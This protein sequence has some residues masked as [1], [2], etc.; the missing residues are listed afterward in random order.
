M[1]QSQF[2]IKKITQSLPLLARDKIEELIQTGPFSPGEKLP[3]ETGL[4]EMLGVS[5]LTIREALRLLEEDGVIVRYQ[6]KGTFVRNSDLIIRNPLE[7]N[8]S[9]TE[10]IQ[11]QGFKA[12]TAWSQLKRAHADRILA[13]TLGVEVESTVVMLER[14]RTASGKPAVYTLD[15]LPEKFIPDMDALRNLQ[16]S[17][18]AFLEENCNQKI[19]YS[20]SKLFPILSEP[21]IVNKLKIEK[22]LPLLLLEEV[23]YTRED[24]PVMCGREYWAPGVFEFSLI[25]RRKR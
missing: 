18:S 13:N 24:K 25:R 23:D 14:V 8:I 7:V 1:V 20:I 2:K 9:V 4:A 6:G 15:V 16:G 5:R 22:A 12:G 3:K 19:E 10:V 11:S 17:L 21:Y